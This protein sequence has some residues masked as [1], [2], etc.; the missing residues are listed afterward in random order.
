MK[1][2]SYTMSGVHFGFQVIPSSGDL[3]YTNQLLEDC[4]DMDQLQRIYKN[5]IIPVSKVI[6]FANFDGL[7]FQ[8]L[9]HFDLFN[10]G[11]LFFVI[12]AQVKLDDYE[13]DRILSTEA[14]LVSEIDDEL[15]QVDDYICNYLISKY[16]ERPERLQQFIKAFLE[17]YKYSSKEE[18]DKVICKSNLKLM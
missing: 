5:S 17:K 11:Y 4:Q 1:D 2:N 13:F 6:D 8:E 14:L 18:V 16:N 3:K 7:N 10:K 12:Y 9:F 15:E